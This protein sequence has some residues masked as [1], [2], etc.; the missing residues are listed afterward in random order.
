MDEAPY[1]I[2]LK[3]GPGY[4]APWIIVKAETADML[5]ARLNAL[6][7]AYA[8]QAASRHAKDFQEAHAYEGRHRGQGSR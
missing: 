7:R 1:T 5:V 8:Y 4:D 6:E 2:T 3:A